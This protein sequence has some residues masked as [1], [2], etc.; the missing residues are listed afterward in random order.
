[1][2]PTPAEV[3]QLAAQG[4]ADIDQTWGRWTL[5]PCEAGCG[6]VGVG[7]PDGWFQYLG[8]ATDGIGYSFLE[9]TRDLCREQKDGAR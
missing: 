9:H 8:R 7:F 4:A 3:E 2:V 1:M 6:A 5:E